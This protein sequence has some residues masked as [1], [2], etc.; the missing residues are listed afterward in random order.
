[1]SR[2]LPESGRRVSVHG[3]CDEAAMGRKWAG[4]TRVVWL[5]RGQGKEVTTEAAMKNSGS[6]YVRI[7]VF[8]SKKSQH[9]ALFYRFFY[10]HRVYRAI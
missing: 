6:L 1:M 8:I 4:P 9:C 3:V 2:P 7:C 5:G 10:I